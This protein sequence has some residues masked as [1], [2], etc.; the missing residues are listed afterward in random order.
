MAEKKTN[1]D[2]RDIKRKLDVI[3]K[4][5]AELKELGVS[6]AV[7]YSTT[8]TNGLFLLGDT[9]ITNII[10]AHKEDILLNPAWSEEVQ[11][12]DDP[13]RAIIIPPLPGPLHELNGVTLKSIIVGVV[14][15]LGLSWSS[16]KPHR[17]P[18]ELP[19]QHPRT[20]PED[21]H[22]KLLAKVPCIAT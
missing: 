20:A 18:N 7:V 10:E 3:K 19:F 21:Y 14:K 5:C 2:A 12:Q 1:N 15:D 17:W 16:A 4:K 8:K 22:G 13:Q 6:I 11:E 9:R